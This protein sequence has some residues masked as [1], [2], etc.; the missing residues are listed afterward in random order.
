MDFLIILL[1]VASCTLS[2]SLIPTIVGKYKF[3]NG[4][5][6]NKKEIMLTFDDGPGEYTLEVLKILKNE[7]IKASFFVVTEYAL[8]NPEIIQEMIRD[9]HTIGLHSVSHNN[10]L[11]RGYKYTKENIIKSI[12]QM[13]RL[14]LDVEYYRPPWGQVNIFTKRILKKYKLEIILWSIITEDW[15]EKTKSS[16]IRDK[17]MKRIKNGSIICLH[18]NRGEEGATIN[19]INALKDVIADLKKDG[20]SFI[21]VGE[22]YGECKK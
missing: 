1:L 5:T 8:E 16:M 9:K 18:D 3:R 15:L 14:G 6:T 20:Y 2:Y 7:N 10:I 4:F 21:T 22:Y 17:I 11:F 13:E 19:M 12:N